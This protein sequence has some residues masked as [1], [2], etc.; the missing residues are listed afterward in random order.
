M[1][2]TDTRIKERDTGT[3]ILMGLLRMSKNRKKEID[4]DAL[5]QY[6]EGLRSDLELALKAMGPSAQDEVVIAEK[7]ST[8]LDQT[9]LP[10]IALEGKWNLAYHAEK[11]LLSL[12]GAER[13]AL[14]L[15]RR[16]SQ[17]KR[18]QTPFAGF[19]EQQIKTL[20]QAKAGPDRSFHLLVSLV[21]DMQQYNSNKHIKMRYARD[22][23]YRVGLAFG[24]SLIVFLSII[25][26]FH[27]V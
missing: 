7:I 26:F 15:K 23:I 4:Y 24:L 8:K 5:S 9:A 19:Y 21:R 6:V 11:L 13:Q 17:C 12:F 14:E 1:S 20:E 16:F 18:D 10:S 22:A 2:D 3:G 25:S 27:W